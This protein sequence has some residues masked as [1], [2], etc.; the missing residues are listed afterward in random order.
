MALQEESWQSS[1]CRTSSTSVTL[2]GV[3]Q[4]GHHEDPKLLPGNHHAMQRLCMKT[5]SPPKLAKKKS[6]FALIDCEC[7]CEFVFVGDKR[8]YLCPLDIMQIGTLG[9]IKC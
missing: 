3:S 4:R 9:F 7:M 6:Q 8:K 1:L 2:Q 5:S